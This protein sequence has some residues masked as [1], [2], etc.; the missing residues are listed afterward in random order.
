MIDR[1]RERQIAIYIPQ[2]NH[3]PKIYNR[4]TH[5]RKEFKIT[6]NIVI[7]SQVKRAKEEERNKKEPK[8]IKTINKMA[9]ID[10]YQ[11]LLSI[12]TINVSGLML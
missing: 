11:Q 8:T 3:K 2:C 7:K 9:I 6:L 12:I 4:Y 1:Q 10:R 5:N